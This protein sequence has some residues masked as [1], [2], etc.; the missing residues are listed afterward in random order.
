MARPHEPLL[1][2]LPERFAQT[3]AC[4][5]ATISA[6]LEPIEQIWTNTI[7][8]FLKLIIISVLVICFDGSADWETQVLPTSYTQP[9]WSRS[10]T[11]IKSAIT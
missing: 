8:L 1:F 9:G 11:L 4:A 3:D 2:R 5:E 6:L 10:F 7:S